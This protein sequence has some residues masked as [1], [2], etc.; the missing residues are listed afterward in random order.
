MSDSGFSQFPPGGSNG[1]PR[2]L[3]QIPGLP[4]RSPERGEAQNV[5]ITRASGEFREVREPTRVTGEVV[6]TNEDGSVRIRTDRGEIDIRVA[7]RQTPP[8]QGQRVEIDLPPGN[9]PS[10][11]VIRPAPAQTTQVEQHP[12]PDTRAVNTPI[13]V[14]IRPP[15]PP[16]QTQSQ[17][18][19]PQDVVRLLPLAANLAPDIA[20]PILNLI[21]SSVV[22]VTEI[23]A[24]VTVANTIT[25][26]LAS[27]VRAPV[28]P[29][30]IPAQIPIV[31]LTQNQ[32]V[33]NLPQ[34]AILQPVLQDLPAANVL[35]PV[36]PDQ[37]SF[38]P[39]QKA[40]LFIPPPILATI[41][42]PLQDITQQPIAA[43]P[44]APQKV[45]PQTLEQAPLQTQI[46]AIVPP[47]VQILL[48]ATQGQPVAE[49][50]AI[51][52]TILQGAPAETTAQVIGFIQQNL[53]V[54]SFA[55]ANDAPAPLFVLQAPGTSLPIGTQIQLIPQ[56]GQAAPPAQALPP[57]A[58]IPAAILNP[59]PS[60]PVLQQIHQALTQVSPQVAQALSNMTPQASNP[61]QLGPAALFFLAAVRSGDISSWLG[62]KAGDILRREGKGNLLSRLSQ[63]GSILGRINAE[64]VSQDWRGIAIPHFW[65]GEMHKMALYYKQDGGGDE[66]QEKSKQTRFIFDLSLTQMGKVQ[67]D[68]LFRATRLDLIVRTES[69]FSQA[70]QMEMKQTYTGAL[71]QTELAGELSFQNRPEQWVK[72]S[73]EQEV[74]S[75]NI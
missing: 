12:V 50:A 19:Q 36:T 62:D 39:P 68:G 1:G 63:E 45:P 18:I 75:A 5:R 46:S 4:E 17:P 38:A 32:P 33:L 2:D 25:E 49:T 27:L 48:P 53:P 23:T 13:N 26:T 58:A 24:Q 54:V 71:A 60:W 73:P 64:P 70:M 8:Q 10:E 51:K 37:V 6:R 57:L 67:L 29:T 61:A 69:Q 55:V 16:P 35:P 72:I 52:P 14:E 40:S 44:G 42:I 43:L 7:E 47:E 28:Q 22:Q 74:Y 65:Q 59:E 15:A 21:Q 41:Q 11:A 9:P 56:T 3:T 34:P 31:A 20:Q 66:Q 30:V